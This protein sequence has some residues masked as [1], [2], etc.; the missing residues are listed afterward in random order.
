MILEPVLVVYLN[1]VGGPYSNLLMAQ[2]LS[3]Y[4]GIV[5]FE[6]VIFLTFI[7]ASRRYNTAR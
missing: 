3:I 4:T 7:I 2:I 1:E 5:E 6:E